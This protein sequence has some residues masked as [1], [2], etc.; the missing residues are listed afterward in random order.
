MAPTDALASDLKPAT[1]GGAAAVVETAVEPTAQSIAIGV[2]IF[3]PPS[4]EGGSNC[5]SEG[6]ASVGDGEKGGRSLAGV[7]L[8]PALEEITGK[9]RSADERAVVQ[10]VRVKAAPDAVEMARK[11]YPGTNYEYDD[12]SREIWMIRSRFED[13]SIDIDRSI[14]R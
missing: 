12:L 6:K 3:T 8:T 11:S 4:P 5:G 9:V 2:S 14:D 7:E 13:R 1:V 10:A